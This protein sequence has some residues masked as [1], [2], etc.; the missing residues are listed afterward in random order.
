M[1]GTI[2]AVLILTLLAGAGGLYTYVTNLQKTAEIHRLNA[3]R[4][5][6]AVAQNEEALRVQKENY[7]ALQANLE[8]VNEEF[9]AARAQNNVLTNKL[10]EHDLNALAAERPKS[11]TR[12]INRGTVNAGRCFEI[13]S[14]APLNDK[15][16]EAK[17]AKSFNNE[18]PWLWP[19][20]TTTD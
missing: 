10:A 13:L 9:R 19:G 12:L 3:E 16:K 1:F 6:V 8:E 11:I 5:E 7:E 17:S 18:C 20:P 2:K 15:E 14:G 4:L